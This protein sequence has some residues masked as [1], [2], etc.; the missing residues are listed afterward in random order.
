M[1]SFFR[2]RRGSAL[3]L[4]PLYLLL[5]LFYLLDLGFVLDNFCAETV[6]LCFELGLGVKAHVGV[7]HIGQSEEGD[8]VSAPVIEEQSVAGN[9][10]KYDCDVVGEAIFAGRD[11]EEFAAEVAAGR[12]TLFLAILARFTKYLFVGN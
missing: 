2:L 10:E 7:S 12:L 5:F 11:V 3:L 6:L 1:E 4:F 8:E 9:E